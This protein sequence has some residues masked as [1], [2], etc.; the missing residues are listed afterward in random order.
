MWNN[1]PQT[2]KEEYKKMILAFAGLTE[3]FAQKA[4][5]KKD[6]SVITPILNSKYQET[7]FQR[8]F[9]GIGEDIGNSAYD[10]SLK[11]QGPSGSTLKYLIGIKTFGISTNFQ[12][13]A[14]FKA[15]NH[16]WNDI[17]NQIVKNSVNSD[18]TQKSKEEIDLANADLYLEMAKKISHLRNMRIDSA[19]AGL[20]GF[21]VQDSG[22]NVESVYH[23]LMPS[24]KGNEPVIAV[25]ELSYDK[26]DIG[27]IKIIGC[28][29]KKTPAN[30]SFE[31]GNHQYRFTHADSQ[32]YMDFHNDDIIK[33]N[34]TVKYAEDAY[35]IFSDIANRINL[36][37]ENDIIDSACWKID[38]NRYSGFNAFNGVGSKMPTSQR[39]K[40]L[41]SLNNKYRTIV[42]PEEWEEIYKNL[43]LFLLT[44]SDNAKLKADKEN[45]R[46]RILNAV[47]S[48]K[49]IDLSNDIRN[50]VY[51]PMNELYIPV[52]R[53]K[54]FHTNHPDFFSTGAGAL[55]YEPKSLKDNSHFTMVM[56]PS[57]DEIECYITQSSGKA[58]ESLEKQ[59]YLGEWIL[60]K[61]FQL[62]DYEVLTEE[63]LN[64]ININGIRLT[65]HKNGKVHFK[66]IWI[67][68]DKL[69]TD[70]IE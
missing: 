56:E 36:Q 42:P 26:I 58:I 70:Y 35:A 27:N 41:K 45:L 29:S 49:N 2:Q 68:E 4:E 48:I 24:A 25:G 63:R 18:N 31:D 37:E 53:S 6:D 15:D 40:R 3:M 34:W 47:D 17:V 64:E 5:S 1:L 20:Q 9:N 13:V 38:I 65:K 8:V 61:V 59:S 60:K 50:T 23:V 21:V 44:S 7:V 12:K 55:I 39:E 57:G 22:D 30:F 10:V 33:E 67:D 46:N 16:N 52:H 66:F 69:P 51:R 54:A 19:I 32:L 11:A 28:T 43:R 14:Q 62:N